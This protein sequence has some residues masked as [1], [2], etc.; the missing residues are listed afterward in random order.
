MAKTKSSGA[1]R[2][3][4]D[5]LP[6]YLGV[7]LFAGQ[8]AKPGNIIV[9]Q[10]GTNFMPGENVK[11]GSDNTLYAAKEGLVDF[12]TKKKRSFDNSIK[13]KRIVSIS[14]VRKANL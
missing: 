2:L 12:I 7:K 6:K 5:A 10:R 3:G 9:R 13:E 14:P 1:T 8:I 4:R 11:M